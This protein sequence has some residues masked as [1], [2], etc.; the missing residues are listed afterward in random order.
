M[1]DEHIRDAM[2]ISA[3][4]GSVAMLEMLHSNGGSVNSRGP[5]GDTLFHL[6][7]LN[8]H[9]DALRWLHYN[10]ILTEAVDIYGTVTVT[11]T[12]DL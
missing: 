10:G 2:Q 3:R 1:V 9:V 8:G 7:A 6:S 12:W 4:N 11:V 5:R